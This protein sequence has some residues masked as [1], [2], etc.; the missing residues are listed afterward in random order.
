M[1]INYIIGIITVV[2]TLIAGEITKKYPNIDKKK[3]IPVQNVIFQ[4]HLVWLAAS[5]IV[6]R[7]SIS[8]CSW[9]SSNNSGSWCSSCAP[10]VWPQALKHLTAL[11]GE[12]WLPTA[13]M[14]CMEKTT[15]WKNSLKICCLWNH[16]TSG[17]SETQVH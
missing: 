16:L 5:N 11:T 4:N 6:N 10:D 1:D 12:C 14:K 8:R 15:E 7:I 9:F 17:Q 13:M 2:I 3:V